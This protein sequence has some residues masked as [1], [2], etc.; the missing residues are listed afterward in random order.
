[1]K[2]FIKDPVDPVTGAYCD[3][4]TDFTLGQTLPLSFT[5]STVQYCHC[6]A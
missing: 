6:M 3:E 4:R 2:K 1:M 5:R